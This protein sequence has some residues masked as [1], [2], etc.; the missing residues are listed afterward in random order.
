MTLG[1]GP[2][3]ELNN[4]A[5]TAQAKYSIKLTE[6]KNIYFDNVMIMV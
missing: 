5:I 2:V 4:T 3:Q 1:E 6:S